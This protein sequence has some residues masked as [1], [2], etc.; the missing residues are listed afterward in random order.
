MKARAGGFT[1]IELLVAV[2]L[3]A[4]IMTVLAFA[5]GQTVKVWNHSWGDDESIRE[6]RR[7]RQR[8]DQE[9]SATGFSFLSRADGPTTLVGKDGDAL[10][11]LSAHDPATGEFLVKSDG[12]PDWSCNV[13]YYAVCPTNLASFGFTGPG[14]ASGGYEVACPYKVLVR[15]VIDSQP[16]P[17]ETLL[18]DVA[19]YL[20][21]PA[22]VDTS[23]LGGPGLVRAEIVCSRLLSF[24]VATDDVV[25]EVSVDLRGVAL[26]RALREVAVGSLSLE[27][28]AYTSQLQ[29]SV[30]PA[31][32]GPLATPTP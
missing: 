18:T 1:Q 7:G 14:L 23:S 29:F 4:I 25:G 9:L 3:F 31:N 13:L 26:R 5:L 8:L 17:G 19:P 15:K 16:G 27:S 2:G 6:L 20:D 11:F 22:G 30:F 32:G 12:T 21:A 28:G 24:R 10:W